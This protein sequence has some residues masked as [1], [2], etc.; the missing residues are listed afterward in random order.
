M[1]D[2]VSCLVPRV[3]LLRAARRAALRV[4]LLATGVSAP[5]LRASAQPG[6]VRLHDAF[7]RAEGGQLVV[8]NARLRLT[9]DRATGAWS[10]LYADGVPGSLIRPD[11][12]AALDVR[13]D[14]AWVGTRARPRLLGYATGVDRGGTGVVLR[15]RYALGTGDELTGVYRVAPG[16][17]AVER[18]AELRAPGAG[19]AG[20]QTR[21]LEDFRFLLP[22]VAV[23][24]PA[25]NAVEVPGPW[26]PKTY[27]RPGTPYPSLADTLADTSRTFH[28]APDGGFGVLAL[29]NAPLG[30]ALASWLDTEG[31]ETNYHPSLRGR[32]GRLD[33]VFV[34]HRAY[35]LAPNGYAESDVQ[36]VEVA[37]G[38]ARDAYAAYRAMLERT[39]PLAAARTP[40]WA[41]E[42]VLLEVYPRYYKRGFRGITER[43]PF[44]RDVGFNT[45]YLMP[46][47]QGGY[48]PVDLYTVDST[49][50]TPAELRTLVD[51]AHRLGMRVL[52]DMV[53][54]G[55]NERSPVPRQ[56]PELFVRDTAGR[57]ARHPTWKSLSTDWA[58]PA[59]AQYMADYVRHDLA[60]YDVDGYRVDAASYK[61]PNWDPHAP[62]PAYASG[63]R[64]PAVMRRMLDALHAQKPDATLLSEVFGPVFYAVSNLAHDN[65]TEAGQWL[66]EAL[67][68][69]RLTAA[70]YK[71]HLASVQALLP[72]GANR[73]FFARNHDTSWFYHFGGY[74]PRFLALDAVHAL[75]A[76]PEVFAGDPAHGPNPDDAPGVWAHYKALFGLR[77][78]YPELARGALLLDEV[79][80]SNPHVFTALRQLGDSLVLVAVSLSDRPE[81]A[82]VTLDAALPA[83]GPF[84]LRDAVTR[85]AV[86][87][88]DVG[89]AGRRLRVTL[90]PFQAVVGRQASTAP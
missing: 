77:G 63:A 12:T 48:S 66:V 80:S 23:G 31:G 42:M 27:V 62:Y 56:R 4:L 24:D 26:F 3:R 71:A 43:L 51:T 28:G 10:G 74:T 84:A 59:Y 83:A 53:I 38:R 35:A 64:S 9:F 30:V 85:G 2:R 34:D 36:R 44:Y 32:G 17:G 67:A 22:G 89:G 47:W 40:A 20:R 87:V 86:R 57:I 58:S 6:G 33:F 73:V 70:D 15:L 90:Q 18:W 19:Q 8:G 54:H 88:E 75:T 72:A 11:G 65:Q 5:H 69:G 1:A 79:R 60:A 25:G 45:V 13:I 16:A 76:I 39:M 61:G 14:G 7:A 78:P 82:E 50:G 41:R 52:F 49:F 37:R 55:F 21:R 46:H 68:A 29:A 81:T